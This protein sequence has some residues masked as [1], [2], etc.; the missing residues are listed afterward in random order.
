MGG[1]EH[2]V[3]PRRARTTGIGI[4]DFEQ[5]IAGSN[6]YIDKTLFIKEWWEN[7]DAVT[8][9]TRPR[10]FGKTLTMDMVRRFFST[11]YAGKGALFEG[12]AIWKEEKYRRLQ[13][14]FPVIF[15]S[16][17]GI[18]ARSFQEAKESICYEIERLYNRCCFLLEGNCL[19]H[20]E[21][22]F[23]ENISA[24]MKGYA[25]AAS[26][27]AISEY[28]CR[29]FGKKVIILLD[30]YDTPMQEAYINGY[31]EELT[32]F[33]CRLFNA[34]FK[35]NP[36]MERAILTGITRI[37]KE[38][39]FSD[40]NNPEVVATTSEKYETSFGFTQQEVWEVLEEYGLQDQKQA[41]R[42]WYDGF[43]F[44]KRRDIY[45]PW[46]ILN[47]LDKRRF[48]PYWA[49]TSENR[50]V[51]R[52]VRE[53]GRDIKMAVEEF[54][55]GR[56]L[57]TSM[58]EQIVFGQLDNRSDAVWSLLLAGGY[59]KVE[60]YTIDGRW[61]E[62]EYE[63]SLTNKEIFLAFRQ[64]IEEWFSKSVP[65]YN[66]F[67]QAL[68]CGDVRRMNRYM[69]EVAFLVF[70]YFD[71]GRHPSKSEPER[72]YHGFV[73]GLMVDLADRY[74]ITSNRE[75]GFGRYDVVMEPRKTQDPAFILE[76]KVYDPDE[77][78]SLEDTVNAAQK[79]I[80]EKGYAA[81]LEAKG[82]AE[83]RIRKYGFAF[84]GKKV[85][86]GSG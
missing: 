36:Y 44:G 20:K 74:I 56:T 66:D 62:A 1:Y 42:E 80:D 34:S 7:Q 69:N 13:G 33:I 45:N 10:R 61:G 60:S 86:I 30:E 12:L 31:W 81:V 68:L 72:F 39:I 19:N 85:L 70:S 8:L 6:L 58:D 5:V 64:M 50:L 79:Q 26:L 43:T 25:A 71:T 37:G 48:A 3:L 17:A 78:E 57:K 46:S 65:V 51:S 21:K 15:L 53:G 47:Y 35:S 82:I 41:V 40:L 76:F 55:R 83:E 75:S 29:Y 38:S 67:I 22:Q 4:Q 14:T 2:A 9:I 11:E 49:N 52:L 16:F 63:L 77:E 23:F 18:K 27:G 24:K 54:L 28:L 73:L 59:L 84:E 32:E